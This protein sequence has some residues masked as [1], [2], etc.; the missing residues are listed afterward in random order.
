MFARNLVDGVFAIVHKVLRCNLYPTG[1]VRQHL[2]QAK[3]LS[4]LFYPRM[5]KPRHHVDSCC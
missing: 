1:C 2:P 5:A 3:Q 4:E